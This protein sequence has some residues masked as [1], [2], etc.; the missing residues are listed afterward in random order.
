MVCPHHPFSAARVALGKAGGSTEEVARQPD[1]L[2]LDEPGAQELVACPSR[3]LD[4]RPTFGRGASW[5]LC[6]KSSAANA[7]V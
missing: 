5:L 7:S 4:L 1:L 3:R 2:G 6:E